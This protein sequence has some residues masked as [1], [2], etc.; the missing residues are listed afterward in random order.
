VFQV[1]LQAALP[2]LLTSRT[3]EGKIDDWRRFERKVC[4]I[5]DANSL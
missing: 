2:P 5:F 4:R 3:L 1:T